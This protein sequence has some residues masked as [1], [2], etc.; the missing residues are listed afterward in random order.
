M[1]PDQL[2]KIFLI[3]HDPDPKNYP[4]KTLLKFGY[5]RERN[6]DPNQKSKIMRI[7]INKERKIYLILHDPDPVV[8]RNLIR[9]WL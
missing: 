5:I 7:K 8:T 9:F 3:L 6:P 4:T 2:R 1:D